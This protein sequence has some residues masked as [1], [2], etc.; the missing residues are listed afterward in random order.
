ML[1]KSA[2]KFMITICNDSFDF[3]QTQYIVKESS[4]KLFAFSH[5]MFHRVEIKLV[6]ADARFLFSRLKVVLLRNT[7][8]GLCVDRVASMLEQ[9]ENFGLNKLDEINLNY[10]CLL[11]KSNDLKLLSCFRI[12]SFVLYGRYG[13]ILEAILDQMDTCNSLPELTELKLFQTY[14]RAIDSRIFQHFTKLE[15]L[16]IHGIQFPYLPHIFKNAHNLIELDLSG[17][18]FRALS[19]DVFI[20]LENS[21][22]IIIGRAD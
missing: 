17:N 14:E 6:R 11:R 5:A 13:L 22:I 4:S 2:Q 19:K 18:C 7:N 1:K 8:L 15:R 21:I 10:N 3:S 9:L 16:C 12:K 20:G